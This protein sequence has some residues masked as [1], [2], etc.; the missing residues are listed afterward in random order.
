MLLFLSNLN[1]IPFLTFFQLFLLI[2]S[3]CHYHLIGSLLK[4]REKEAKRKVSKKAGRRWNEETKTSVGRGTT[5]GEG[6]KDL[7]AREHPGIKPHGDREIYRDKT[8]KR[9]VQCGE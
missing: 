6:Q 4:L 3:G 9:H 1:L 2:Q 5:E 8:A 7:T